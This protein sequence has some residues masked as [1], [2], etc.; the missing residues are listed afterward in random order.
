MFGCLAVYDGDKIVLILR[1]RDKHRRDNGVWLATALEH[2]ESLRREL[3]MMRSIG[4]FGTKQTSWQVVPADA[5]QFEEAARRVCELVLMRDTRIGKVP[6]R[7]SLRSPVKP[8][9]ADTSKKQRPAGHAPLNLTA[10]P[11]TSSRRRA[12]SR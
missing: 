11:G 10:T 5:A 2:H 3:P 6:Q 9:I 4:L 1:D 7:R 12:R 8:R